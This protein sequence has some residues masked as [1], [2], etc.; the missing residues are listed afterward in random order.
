VGRIRV[1]TLT[2]VDLV[3]YRHTVWQHT[4]HRA[5]T[6]L[7][8]PG[9]PVSLPKV[10]RVGRFKAWGAGVWWVEPVVDGRVPLVAASSREDIVEPACRRASC[11]RLEGSGFGFGNRGLGWGI[12]D[13][14]LACREIEHVSRGD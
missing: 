6:G 11:Q 10:I 3:L 4:G 13:W 7:E 1:R 2:G 8:A 14:E 12:G 5:H 9:R